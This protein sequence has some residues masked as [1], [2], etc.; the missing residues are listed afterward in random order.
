MRTPPI[1]AARLARRRARAAGPAGSVTTPRGR[2][3]PG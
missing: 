3:G 2:A 1:Q